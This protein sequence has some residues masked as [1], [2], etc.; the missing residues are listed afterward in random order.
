MF[1]RI[2]N[3]VPTRHPPGLGF[4]T[5]PATQPDNSIATRSLA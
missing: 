4:A 3:V 1:R 5:I 2:H